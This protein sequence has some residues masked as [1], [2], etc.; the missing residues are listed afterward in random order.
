MGYWACDVP[1]E[2]QKETLRREIRELAEI[3]NHEIP[4]E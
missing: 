2:K 1:E 4:R 3:F